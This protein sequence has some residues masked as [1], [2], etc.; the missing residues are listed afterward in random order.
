MTFD[1]LDNGREYLAAAEDSINM[2]WPDIH[3][4]TTDDYVRATYLATVAATRALIGIGRILDHNTQQPE[5]GACAAHYDT[6]IAREFSTTTPCTYSHGHTGAHR[7]AS[8]DTW[9]DHPPLLWHTT[10]QG[11]KAT[12]KNTPCIHNAEHDGPH[13]DMYGS[14]WHTDP[15]TEADAITPIGNPTTF[16]APHTGIYAF[17]IPTG[18]PLE[19]LPEGWVQGIRNEYEFEEMHPGKE[20]CTHQDTTTAGRTIR[21][22]NVAGHEHRGPYPHIAPTPGANPCPST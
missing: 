12:L 21:C 13:T 9:T 18:R 10:T 6:P 2:I 11:C 5:R 1:R 8:G 19:L 7:A 4:A 3:T 14:T 15:P 20:R 17:G 22:L 16:T